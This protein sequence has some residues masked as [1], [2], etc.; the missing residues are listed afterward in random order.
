MP[1]TTRQAR[2]RNPPASALA[3]APAPAPPSTSSSPSEN[4]DFN[5]DAAANNPAP[6]PVVTINVADLQA[7]QQR[8]ADLEAAQHNPHRRHRSDS[9][10]VHEPAPKHT[11]LKG[12][13]PDE[14][15]GENHQKLDAFIRQCKNNFKIDGCTTIKVGQ[16]VNY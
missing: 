3:P 11:H 4:G 6:N 5:P 13:S 14:Y 16:L 9:E 10:C 15:E 1:S 2:G 8:I 7:I 12:K